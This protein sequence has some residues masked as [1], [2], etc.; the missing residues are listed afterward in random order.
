MGVV[1]LDHGVGLGFSGFAAFTE[2]EIFADGALEAIPD[3]RILPT[4]V[5]S[6]AKVNL[7]R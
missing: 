4:S 7:V 5:T 2:I 6:D 1:N 3:D